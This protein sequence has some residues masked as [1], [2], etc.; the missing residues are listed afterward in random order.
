VKEFTTTKAIGK[1]G[2]LA[3][4]GL[5][6]LDKKLYKTTRSNAKDLVAMAD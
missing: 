3:D 1:R 2:Y 4:I 5:V 6:P